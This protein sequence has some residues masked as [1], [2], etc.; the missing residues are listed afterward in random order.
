METCEQLLTVD[1]HLFLVFTVP[2]SR[3]PCGCRSG[4]SLVGTGGESAVKPE[5]AEAVK[6][7]FI[8]QRQSFVFAGQEGG[9]F[10]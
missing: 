7:D 6:V 3:T 2:A 8:P 10:M 4:E 5:R 9:H 1:H